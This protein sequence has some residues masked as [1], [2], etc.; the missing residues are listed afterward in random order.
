MKRFK[1]LLSL[2]LVFAL[3]M[4]SFAACSNEI[5]DNSEETE[6]TEEDEREPYSRGS[7]IPPE[8]LAPGE[9]SW[10]DAH[11]LEYTPEG[12]FYLHATANSAGEIQDIPADLRINED[13]EGC[14][15]GYR[16]IVGIF[17]IDT[18]GVSYSSYW[19]STFDKYTG[20]SF[21]FQNGSNT[22]YNGCHIINSGTVELHIAGYDYTITIVEDI[23]QTD[24]ITIMTFTVTCPAE[25]DGLV[26]QI[27]YSDGH[28]QTYNFG[29]QTYY[30]DDFTD[31]TSENY[32]YFTI[33]SVPLEK[34]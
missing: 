34:S 20:T 27:G 17:T 4:I 12:N 7:I 9:V 8:Y 6:E 21:E 10:F 22:I 5:N 23:V 14:E 30:A 2:I 3:I 15:D 32:N 26:F 31:V 19:T 28:D 29:N 24:D 18:R 33:Q 13:T 11:G 25:Y 16:N 1:K